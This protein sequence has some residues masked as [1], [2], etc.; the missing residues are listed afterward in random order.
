MAYLHIT[1]P[2]LIVLA[3]FF[4]YGYKDDFKRN[5]KEFVVTVLSIFIVFIVIAVAARIHLLLA[6][7]LVL[8]LRE[9]HARYIL[10]NKAK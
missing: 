2:V 4:Y 5:P 3:L 8:V 10:R 1:I 7:V 6:S 9:L